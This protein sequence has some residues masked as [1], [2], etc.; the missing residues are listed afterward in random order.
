MVI[1]ELE[2]LYEVFS[3]AYNKWANKERP[4]RGPNS[5]PTGTDKNGDAVYVKDHGYRDEE[6][7]Y[8]VLARDRYLAAARKARLAELH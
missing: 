7:F 5:V 3:E 2:Q 6:W 8:Y 4:T 1:M